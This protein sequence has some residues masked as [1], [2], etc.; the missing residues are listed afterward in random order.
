MKHYKCDLFFRSSIRLYPARYCNTGAMR[1][2]LELLIISARQIG[3]WDLQKWRGGESSW[4]YWLFCFSCEES[5]RKSLAESW[6]KRVFDWEVQTDRLNLKL[7]ADSSWN[8]VGV[9]QA[10]CCLWKC[11]AFSLW[12][13][14]LHSGA[15]VP[16]PAEPVLPLSCCSWLGSC[17]IRLQLQSRSLLGNFNV[18]TSPVNDLAILELTSII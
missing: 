7:I 18:P 2:L 6:K 13:K 14:L 8:M 10:Q 3:V 16:A 12:K 17:C 15:H 1:N 11:R 5:K 4:F 9:S